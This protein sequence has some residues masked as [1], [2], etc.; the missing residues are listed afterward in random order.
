MS[1]APGNTDPE[2]D[3]PEVDLVALSEDDEAI[4]DDEVTRYLIVVHGAISTSSWSIPNVFAPLA[5]KT[6]ITRNPTFRTRISLP[7]GD[8]PWNSSRTMVF[9]TRHTR[10]ELRSS[11][12]PNASPSSR[13]VHSRTA[14]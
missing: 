1:A 7:T 3:D 5:F 13:S 12:S 10:A 14:R 9:P 2:L 4:D 11:D 6:P 8:W